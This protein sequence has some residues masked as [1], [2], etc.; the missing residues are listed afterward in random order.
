[1]ELSVERHTTGKLCT[2]SEDFSVSVIKAYRVVEV[3]LHSFLASALYGSEWLTSL[4]GHLN[5]AQKNRYTLNRRL[6]GPQS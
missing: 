1:M 5:T 4:P 6:I 3:Y 2:D